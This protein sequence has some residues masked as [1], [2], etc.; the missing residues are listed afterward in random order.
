MTS[1]EAGA[2]AAQILE[3][4]RRQDLAVAISTI[5]EI[6]NR[7]SSRDALAEKAMIAYLLKYGE[8]DYSVVAEFA[9]KMADAMIVEREKR[10]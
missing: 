4:Q 7:A 8:R 2:H 1:G 6:R 5:E 9:Y 3:E 10:S